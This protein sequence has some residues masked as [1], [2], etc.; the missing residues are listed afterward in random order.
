MK[1]LIVRADD[2]GYS[3]AVNLGMRKAAI[4]GFITCAGLMT[5]MPYAKQGAALLKDTKVAL[6]VH[7]N[8]CVGPSITN[9]ELIQSLVDCSTGEFYSSKEIKQRA[10]DEIKFD[11]A[12]LEVHAQIDRFVQLVDSNP[13]YVDAHGIASTTFL[14]AVKAVCELRGLLYVDV[15]D[16][17]WLA[18]NNITLG[19]S[20]CRST[21]GMY[22]PYAY[23]LEDEAQIQDAA[24]ALIIFHPGYLDHYLLTHSSF[25][26]IRTLE[27]AMLCD[28]SMKVW[29]EKQGY[30]LSDFTCLTKEKAPIPY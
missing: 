11:E 26:E 29:I 18:Q 16:S 25:T 1:Q 8:I 14:N 2:L 9:C 4:D 5:N 10:V 12:C 15:F 27:L 3:E 19:A 7:V 28:A 21:N 6:G 23:L 22:D 30:T 17:T 20:Q 24:T 13:A